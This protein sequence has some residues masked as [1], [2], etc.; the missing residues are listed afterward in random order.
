MDIEQLWKNTQEELRVVLAPAVYQTFVVKTQ[1]VSLVNLDAT[2]ACSNAYLCDL[3]QKRYYQLFKSA[4]DN[5]T[6]NNNTLH[7]VVQEIIKNDDSQNPSL[8]PLFSY[9]PKTSSLNHSQ[10]GLH[11]KYTLDNLIVGNSNNFA[12]AAAQGVVKNPGLSY[13]PFFLWGGV[14]VGK[15]HLMQAIGHELLKNNPDLKIKY[16][17]AET[18]G[19]ELI[20]SLKTKS[21]NQFKNKY[22]QLDC[23]L[24]DDV[25]FL[26]GKEY[27][28]EEFFH[29][30]NALHLAGKQIILTSD[31]KPG[32]IKDL[33][34]RLVS[35]FMGGLTVDIQP[36]D[37]EM[38]SAIIQQKAQEK[39]V[40]LTFEAVQFL[41]DN[42]QSNTR[43]IEGK[44]QEIAVM[45]LAQGHKLV[46]IDFVSAYF[47][48]QNGSFSPSFAST[49]PKLNSRH[50]LSVCAKYFNVKTGDLCGSSRKKD[51]VTAR[52][53][54]AYLLLNEIKIP[55]KEVGDL[56]G[57]RDH[58]S[59][60][61]ARDKVA[62]ELATSPQLKELINRIKNSL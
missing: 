9:Q 58:T 43:D 42:I 21:I 17:P 14:G 7:F 28:Q 54:T 26:A 37:L 22:R 10:A 15:T 2:I 35:R 53:I 33:E 55:L 23:I 46:D 34:D 31:R 56:L 40:D 50:L 16:F 36:P 4:L 49:S 13:N 11:P 57:G 38:R 18:F 1:L 25:Q 45:S 6:K 27:I 12:Y 52:H 29:T 32:D 8:T 20:N 19:N 51:L 39:G 44:V 61:H 3:N 59:I 48:S 60:M 41:A 5:Q 62:S 24:V 47:S 30:F